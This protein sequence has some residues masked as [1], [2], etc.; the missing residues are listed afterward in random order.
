MEGRGR[1]T[2]KVK[3]I[4]LQGNSQGVGTSLIKKLAVCA[5]LNFQVLKDQGLL[6]DWVLPLLNGTIVINLCLFHHCVWVWW[7]AQ[8]FRLRR[9]TP[10]QLH[11]HLNLTSMMMRS[12]NLS[13]C[14]NG[15]GFLQALGRDECIFHMGGMQIIHWFWWVN[16][17]HRFFDCL[18]TTSELAWQL[19]YGMSNTRPSSRPRFQ[20]T[21][22]STSC[23]LEY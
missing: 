12:W 2:Q 20:E 17:S 8:V 5:G 4:A 15:T 18:P 16:K 11:L 22:A 6:R 19:E 7:G 1:K 23:S 13:Q 9:F 10:N 21:E 14:H 3:L